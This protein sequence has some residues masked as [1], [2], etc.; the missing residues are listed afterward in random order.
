MPAR[1]RRAQP[2]YVMISVVAE[3]YSIHPQTLRLYER[4]GLIKPA[5]SSGNTRLYDEE[6]I[7]RLEIILA[8][9]RDL[10]VN[11]A[12]VEVILNMKEHMEQMQGEV[13]RLLDY[14]RREAQERREAMQRQGALVK[15]QGGPLMKRG[16]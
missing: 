15:L 10:G 12:G 6:A 11:L 16:S 4:E 2:K 5:R 8:L 3:R 1:S 13:D 7:R 9:T 14:V